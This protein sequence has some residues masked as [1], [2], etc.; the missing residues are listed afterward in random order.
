MSQSKM[1]KVESLEFQRLL[2]HNSV[3]FGELNMFN[4][5]K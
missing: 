1:V 3:Q 5:A 2:F 4:H